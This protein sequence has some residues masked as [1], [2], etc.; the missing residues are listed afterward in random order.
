MADSHGLHITVDTTRA[1]QAAATSKTAACCQ[2]DAC[3]P[4][5][6]PEVLN[7]ASRTTTRPTAQRK[8]STPG[9]SVICCVVD[10]LT[11]LVLLPPVSA[12]CCR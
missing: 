7:V 3:R 8:V 6:W 1:S 11:N 5:R 12:P 2:L 4:N 9:R 10:P